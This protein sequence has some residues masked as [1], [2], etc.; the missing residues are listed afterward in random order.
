MSALGGFGT[1]LVMSWFGPWR[2]NVTYDH[3]KDEIGFDVVV[4]AVALWMAVIVVLPVLGK[5]AGGVTIKRP[6][7]QVDASA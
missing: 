7:T 4:G 2:S 1:V 5:R 3:R 6:V